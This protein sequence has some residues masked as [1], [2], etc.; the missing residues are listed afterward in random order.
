MWSCPVCKGALSE[1]ERTLS[2][3]QNHRYDR[4]KEGYVNL[5]LANQKRSKE[6][7]D[8]KEMVAARRAFLE[9]GH[10]DPLIESIASL[11]TTHAD[12]DRQLHLFD[13]GCGEGYYLNGVATQLTGQDRF[14]SGYGCDIAKVAVQKAA[15]KY[16]ALNFAVASTFN[17][18]VLTDSCDGVMQVFAP[19]A[20]SEVSR[21]LRSGGIWLQVNPGPEH[22]CE[23]KQMIYEHA[24]KH[25]VIEQTPEGFDLVEEDNLTF[26]VK[27]QDS[28]A[29][30]NL[31]KMTPF[32]WSADDNAKQKMAAGLSD[33]TADFHVRVLRKL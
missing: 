27:L 9:G 22:L 30:E 21:I 29:C 10:Y 26:T 17:L 7:G 33:V 5:L 24:D 3:A 28:G 8:S 11:I 15:K 18:P 31:L 14:G 6:P 1:Q 32:Y 4:A 20:P 13:A 19:A 23:M 16:K 2:C 25:E 12:S